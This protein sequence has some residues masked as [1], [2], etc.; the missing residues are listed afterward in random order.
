MANPGNAVRRT[1]TTSSD[2]CLTS[3]ARASCAAAR[4][5][6]AG[7][8]NRASR[9]SRAGRFARRLL[10]AVF[11]AGLLAAWPAAA[12][13]W[14]EYQSLDDAVWTEVTNSTG[15]LW[16]VK[17]IND[18][19]GTD[20]E[21][22]LTECQ[23]PGITNAL[24]NGEWSLRSRRIT[25]A[26]EAHAGIKP[27]GQDTR[28]WLA[29][30]EGD[31]Y[32]KPG[33]KVKAFAFGDGDVL[34][35]GGTAILCVHVH[36]VET[37]DELPT[38]LPPWRPKEDP[39]VSFASASSSVGEGE[40]SASVTVHLDPAPSSNLEIGYA[41]SGT[42]TEGTD[43]DYSIANSG[44]I[45]V[46]SGA[47][48][49]TISVTIHDDDADESDETA[50][51]TLSPGAGYTVGSPDAHTL[52]IA[53]D[54][55][56]PPALPEVTLSAAPNPVNEGASVTVT[57]TLSHA[58]AG[59]VAIP[60]VLTPG[61]AEPDDYGALASIEIAGGETSGTGVIAT[62]KD[63]DLDD[64]TF[65]VAIA[66]GTLADVAAGAPASVEVTIAD[67]TGIVSI[68]SPEEELPAS[69]ALEQNYPNPFNPSTT[70]AF[71]LDKAQHVTLTVYDLL[72]QEVRVLADGTLPAARHRVSFDASELAS[73]AYVYMLQTEERVA[74]KT[75]ALLK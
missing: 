47:S 52:V 51:W 59:S 1:R 50:I 58:L 63:T 29:V 49:A 44:V 28:G 60:I 69:F 30:V 5:E 72:G 17:G 46:A 65:T 9:A 10:L 40:G 68:E 22:D 42:A 3:C 14:W 34:Q 53:D 74:I 38:P 56:P 67:G 39:A 73:G 6:R 75:M 2:R 33:Y 37:Q 15:V 41:L 20:N 27:C 12:Q 36:V 25:N 18:F 21:A 32:V 19:N 13:T 61:S 70:I 57:A 16:L 35:C 24:D 66:T 71:S 4:K 54:D 43:G 62:V 11:A 64:E 8:A 7:R 55:A 23:D 26:N 48:T 45:S 31:A